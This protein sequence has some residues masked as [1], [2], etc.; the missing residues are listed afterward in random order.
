[1]SSTM[2]ENME[3]FPNPDE[4]ARI[5]ESKQ[6]AELLLTATTGGNGHGNY[7]PASFLAGASMGQIL[8]TLTLLTAAGGTMTRAIQIPR[9]LLHLADLVGMH[10]G[11]KVIY[12][13]DGGA[14]PH[15]W[16][17]FTNDPM[18]ETVND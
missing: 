13:D 2:P 4:D 5:E 11:Y 18:V 6:L 14:S 3:A 15:A 1:M 9:E 17:K 12:H 8:A 7:E 10:F 16:I